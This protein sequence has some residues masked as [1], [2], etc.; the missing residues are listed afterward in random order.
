MAA[1][2]ASPDVASLFPPYV[3]PHL[4]GLPPGPVLHPDKG[5]LNGRCNRTACQ[6]PLSTANRN[7]WYR[8]EYDGTKLYYCGVC[9]RD[10]NLYDMQTGWPPRCTEVVEEDAPADE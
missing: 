6:R 2:K 10:F 7:Q 4:R 5:K 1:K 9:A 8:T 3:P